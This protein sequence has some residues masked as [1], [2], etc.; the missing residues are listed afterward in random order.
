MLGGLSKTPILLQPLI[1]KKSFNRKQPPLLRESIKRAKL[2]I[3]R[4]TAKHRLSTWFRSSRM[5]LTQTP[6][7]NM[8]RYSKLDTLINSEN[9][10][11]FVFSVWSC[12]ESLLR[13]IRC[14]PTAI[15]RVPTAACC[16]WPIC[17][18]SGKWSSKWLLLYSSWIPLPVFPRG[19]RRKCASYFRHSATSKCPFW[20]NGC[21]TLLPKDK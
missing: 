1:S 8:S 7:N 15:R 4:N 21:L 2:P 6:P 12:P 17:S 10:L 18:S 3:L 9:I 16:P 19:R 13:A 20:F 11:T 5:V 14:L